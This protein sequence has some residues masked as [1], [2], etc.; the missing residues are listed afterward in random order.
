MTVKQLQEPLPKNLVLH[1]GFLA[2]SP[3][4]VF[5]TPFPSV[6]IKNDH[7]RG[8]ARQDTEKQ[9]LLQAV[10]VAALVQSALITVVGRPVS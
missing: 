3:D 4:P 2:G 8:L 1:P 10:Q 7:R 9:R 6:R 5:K